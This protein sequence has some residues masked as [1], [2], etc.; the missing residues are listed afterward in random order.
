MKIAF[1]GTGIMG[2]PMAMHLLKAGYAMSVYNRTKAKAMS[3]VA[4]GA[5]WVDSPAEA[6]RDADFVI[7]MVS[8]TPDVEKVIFASN[9]VIHS[10]KQGAVFID[11]STICADATRAFAKKVR[12]VG[13][14]YLDAPVSGGDIG[15]QN[16]SLAIMVGGKEETFKKALPIFKVMG[17]TIQLMGD[18]GAGQVT[19]SCNQ[20][21]AVNAL[22]GVCEAISLAEKQGL[23]AS[24]MIEAVSN[25][26]ASSFQLTGVG[27]KVVERDFAPGFMVGLMLKDLNIVK[28]LAKESDLSLSSTNLLVEQF[29]KLNQAGEGEQ[30]TQA[31]VKCYLD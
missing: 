1:I 2:A 28:Q 5:K 7:T 15:A 6:A 29:E 18:V 11:M 10:I 23:D 19:K 22:A 20:I 9:G 21:L 4:A 14:D 30:G 3:L 26:A 12:A 31:L 16:A 24:K 27:P 8:D 13:A 17:K 25:G